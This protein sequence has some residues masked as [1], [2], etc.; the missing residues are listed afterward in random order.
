MKL[1]DSNEC[2]EDEFETIS[3]KRKA[4]VKE[5]EARRDR[6]GRV[7]PGSGKLTSRN[8]GDANEVVQNRNKVNAQKLYEKR[9]SREE[10]SKLHR[11][12]VA[13]VGV[14]ESDGESRVK[15]HRDA[16]MDIGDQ[17][18]VH[19]NYQYGNA[20]FSIPANGS[21]GTCH[22][23]FSSSPSGQNNS[24]INHNNGAYVVSVGSGGNLQMN[25]VSHPN[26]NLHM[27]GPHSRLVSR[28]NS[29]EVD[30]E[31]SAS[32][33]S[34]NGGEEEKDRGAARSRKNH[35]Q[36]QTRSQGKNKLTARR[37][38]P[39]GNERSGNS[40]NEREREKEKEE[41]SGKEYQS[42]VLSG[43]KRRNQI[44]GSSCNNMV[45]TRGN[46]G[47]IHGKGVSKNIS[48]SN[49][50]GEE[51]Y[52]DHDYPVTASHPY[53]NP[54]EH[55][56]SDS[57]SAMPPNSGLSSKVKFRKSKRRMSFPRQL[58]GNSFVAKEQSTN[59]HIDNSVM[60]ARRTGADAASSNQG[61]VVMWTDDL[62]SRSVR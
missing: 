53:N 38:F 52:T 29:M 28:R 34:D 18:G 49:G 23:S 40:E 21:H 6:E 5:A 60:S 44:H 11:S 3:D 14:D 31:Y 20:S 1:L 30:N 36:S 35:T 55:E 15:E 27:M 56:V 62:D 51:S 22:S 16:D 46:G 26:F 17:N 10:R 25:S 32:E 41:V 43:E 54:T 19:S 42:S 58:S 50:L 2:S 7:R 4:A 61:V 8:E 57:D 37:R 45:G 39:Y 48:P 59:C 47:S 13:T 33:H 9:I 24:N 12:Q